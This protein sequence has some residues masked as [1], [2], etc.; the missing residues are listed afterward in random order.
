MSQCFVIQP[1]DNG[2]PFDLRYDE[3][4]GP[5]IKAA[6]LI[7]YRVDRDPAVEIPIDEIEAGIK[8]SIVCIADIST[9]SPNVW[10]EVG[11]ARA[12][13][14]GLVL[15]C[16]EDRPEKFPFDIQHRTIIRYGVESPS[17]FKKMGDEITARLN[18]LAMK[19]IEISSLRIS[20]VVEEA[21]EV[22]DTH[23]AALGIVL[24]NCPLPD[25]SVSGHNVMNDMERAGYTKAMSGLV[26]RDLVRRG[27][28]ISVNEI[29]WNGNN[30]TALKLT[31]VGENWILANQG[32]LKA[33]TEGIVDLRG[34]NELP[35]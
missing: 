20:E 11:Y 13:G 32:R 15:I 8:N 30:Y 22:P 7:P 1:F 31:D 4:V 19:E 9:N 3:V 18:A 27:F 6:E 24:G 21:S 33:R 25:D 12:Q 29:D 26:I 2:G 14:K 5:A 17:A 35:F 23:I 16:S 10:Y 34:P 28:L